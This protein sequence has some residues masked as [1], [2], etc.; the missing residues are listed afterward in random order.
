MIEEHLL[1]ADEDRYFAKA[2]LLKA[3]KVAFLEGQTSERKQR[4]V[5][6]YNKNR[7]GA[8]AKAKSL[9]YRSW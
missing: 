8:L 6:S 1:F 5:T 3:E 4:W 2:T 9:L 7:D